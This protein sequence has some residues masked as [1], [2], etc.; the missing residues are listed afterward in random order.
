M[1]KSN[2]QITQKQS[3][4][5]VASQV[6]MP[7]ALSREN[8][9]LPIYLVQP[10]QPHAQEK[11]LPKKCTNKWVSLKNDVP[12]T[13]WF[14]YNNGT[15]T[16]EDLGWLPITK[17]HTKS[18]HELT[19]DFHHL[20]CPNSVSRISK[21]SPSLFVPPTSKGILAMPVLLT[22]NY[23][24]ID[25]KQLRVKTPP[26][27]PAQAHFF[28][29]GNLKGKLNPSAK[30]KKTKLVFSREKEEEIRTQKNKL[31]SIFSCFLCLFVFFT[32]RSFCIF[33]S[34]FS[35]A[36]FVFCSDRRVSCQTLRFSARPKVALPPL[37]PFLPS[38]RRELICSQVTKNLGWCSWVFT[39]RFFWSF[40]ENFL[41][42]VL[43]RGRCFPIFV[44][45]VKTVM[46]ISDF[47]LGI[48][49]NHGEKN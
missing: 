25:P 41:F 43:W 3:C 1:E 26:K 27:P 34:K 22:Q 47:L 48:C 20:R 42:W 33:T 23:T 5:F 28:L 32:G 45:M 44:W 6:Y 12:Q 24:S 15:I 39:R 11:H 46:I 7:L 30:N 9:M 2:P 4:S 40:R 19:T 13:K 16:S 35:L 31:I 14:S 37:L 29:V 17:T 18:S 21:R 8:S 49:L 10:L 38:K 36:S